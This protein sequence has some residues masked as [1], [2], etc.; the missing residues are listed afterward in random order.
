M[1]ARLLIGLTVAALTLGGVGCKKKPTTT[2][3]SPATETTPPTKAEEP[4]ASTPAPAP[5]PEKIDPRNTNQGGGALGGSYRAGKRTNILNDMS[6]LGIFMEQVYL[7]DN[8]MP[9][10]ARTKAELTTARN[11]LKEIDEGYIILTGTKNHDGLWAYEV[12]ADKAGGVVLIAG[13]A[14]RMPVAD[15]VKQLLAQK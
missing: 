11:I 8:K 2:A 9:D 4:A 1:T 10:I 7:Q 13:R 3:G 6:Q 14:Q 5:A 12:D 15:D